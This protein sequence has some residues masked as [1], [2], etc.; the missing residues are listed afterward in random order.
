M[1]MCGLL[2]IVLLGVS[3]GSMAMDRDLEKDGRRGFG[4][5]GSDRDRDNDY[6]CD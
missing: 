2:V 6:R 5:R 3:A 1:N 4:A